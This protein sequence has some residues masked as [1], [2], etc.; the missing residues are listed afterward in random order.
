MS[1]LDRYIIK[2]ILSFVLLCMGVLVALGALV[3][4]VGQQPDIGVGRYSVESAM[5]FTL[6]NLPLQIYQLL[7]ITA[8]IGSLLGLG[9]LARGS[10]LT[11]I[12][13]T[14]VSIGRIA[15]TAAVAGVI[16]VVLE[17]MLGELIAPQLQEAAREQKT[18]LKYTSVTFGGS[19]GAWVRDGNLILNVTGQSGR[20]QFGGMEIFELSPQHRLVAV[21]RAER[22]FAGAN[23]KWLLRDYTE[24]RFKDDT[25]HATPPEQRVLESHVTA[26][27][28]GLAV[29]D[30][31][32]LT[33]T[34]LFELI[35]YYQ[36]NS[37]DARQ[38][39]FHFWSRIAR[40]VAI[41]FAVVLA[42][43][44]VLGSLR[45]S[46]AGTRTMM[47]LILGIGFFLLQRM[48]ESGTNVFDL[49]PVLL[50]WMPTLLLG[51][52]TLLLLSRAMHGSLSG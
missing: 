20:A 15:L 4:F 36:K 34:G 22:A 37:L 16:L 5:W 24:S 43:P 12:R 21:G 50:A 13:A 2:T 40:T 25:V 46:G 23:N 10:E 11:V 7:P 19:S 49:N 3:V 32:M 29:Q 52:V 1:T 18:F 9:S 8:L 31:E 41:I 30:P 39:V 33:S 47:G 44:F 42:I 26:A 35:R 17:V 38:Y 14:G 27:F 6:L 45:S 51:T 28:L 48:T